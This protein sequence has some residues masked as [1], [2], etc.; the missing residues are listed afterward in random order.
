MVEEKDTELSLDH[1]KGLEFK[2]G[3]SLLSTIPASGASREG[4]LKDT[5]PLPFYGQCHFCCLF[6]AT[7]ATEAVCGC[8]GP[9]EYQASCFIPIL[10]A[11]LPLSHDHHPA[12]LLSHSL[13]FADLTSALSFKPAPATINRL[14]EVTVHPIVEMVFPPY[15][16][17]LLG[18]GTLVHTPSGQCVNV[19]RTKNLR[20]WLSNPERQLR[21]TGGLSLNSSLSD[22]STDSQGW[23][24]R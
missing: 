4:I 8:D 1:P 17:G 18:S 12:C 15:S 10:M 16:V 7:E 6:S 3:S 23:Q 11:S 22:S 2:G 24:L 5:E 21:L 14:L 20:C 19:S 9:T 13:Q